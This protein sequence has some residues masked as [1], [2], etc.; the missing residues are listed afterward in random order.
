MA[1]PLNIGMIGF[2]N[3]GAGVVRALT[4]NADRNAFAAYKPARAAGGD[5]EIEPASNTISPMSRS[6]KG[7][8]RA[9]AERVKTSTTCAER[10]R[11]RT[12]KR[13]NES[14]R[15]DCEFNL[16]GVLGERRDGGA[17][18]SINCGA[19]PSRRKQ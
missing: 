18:P 7:R 10:P 9:I 15:R 13:S 19:P 4:T 1:S 12:S 8:G 6:E 2:G 5:F 3:I 17:A 16:F 14:P 11:S